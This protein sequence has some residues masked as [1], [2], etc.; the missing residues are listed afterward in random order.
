MHGTPSMF[1]M[2]A[3]IVYPRHKSQRWKQSMSQCLQQSIYPI[4]DND[5]YLKAASISLFEAVLF[6]HYTVM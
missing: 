2:T 3:C 5:L 6:D 1:I 4:N